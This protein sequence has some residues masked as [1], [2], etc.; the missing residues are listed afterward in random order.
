MA[1][2]EC[3]QLYPWRVKRN[4]G[5]GIIDAGTPGA[6]A[7][8]KE[9]DVRDVAQKVYEEGGNTE[10][11]LGR[12]Q[13]IRLMSEYLFTSSARVATQTNYDQGTNKDMASTAYGAVNCLPVH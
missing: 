11:L 5:T 2:N 12:P 4:F 9:T 10:Y 3:R 13:V 1:E 6:A 8:L 7:A